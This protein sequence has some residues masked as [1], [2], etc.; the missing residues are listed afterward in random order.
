VKL[1]ALAITLFLSLSIQ[2]YEI[3]ARLELLE[4]ADQWIEGE[5]RKSK[6][7]IW[8]IEEIDNAFF[9]DN[10]EGKDFVEHFYV[11][12][13]ISNKFSAN[14]PTAYEVIANITLK[15]H[16][17]QFRPLLWNYKALVIPINING[18]NIKKD[19]KKIQEYVVLDNNK[20]ALASTKEINYYIYIGAGTLIALIA[21]VIVKV[22]NKKRIE[23]EIQKN[24][25]HWKN[26]VKM[27]ESRDDIEYLYEKRDKWIEALGG[28]NPQFIQLLDLIN[29]HQ[30]KREWSNDDISEIDFVLSEIKESL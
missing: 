23:R 6:L 28:Q 15:K 17:N 14:N 24:I 1:I 29:K 16:F 30:Y 9:K 25:D 20:G 22:S 3:N 19:P 7:T 8:P 27:A 21:L 11:S 13:V 2:A 5:T 10:M 26:L 4:G 18:I 12:K